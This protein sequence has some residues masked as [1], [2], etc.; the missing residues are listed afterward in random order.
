MLLIQGNLPEFLSAFEEQRSRN[1]RESLLGQ[2]G[3]KDVKRQRNEA[4]EREEI[5]HSDSH[6]PC[7]FLFPNTKA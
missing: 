6:I 5:M 4:R 3:A 2:R 7:S 1:L